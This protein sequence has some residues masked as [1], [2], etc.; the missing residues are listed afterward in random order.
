[1]AGAVGTHRRLAAIAALPRGERRVGRR[2]CLVIVLSLLTAGTSRADSASSEGASPPPRSGWLTLNQLDAYLEFEGEYTRDR[3]S[4][5]ASRRL[6]RDRQQRQHSYDFEERIGLT[7]HFTVLDPKILTVSTDLSF[8]LTQDRFVERFDG[9]EQ[10]D[11]DNGYLIHHDSRLDFFQGGKVS[12]SLYGRRDDRRINRRFQPTLNED[13]IGYGTS[14]VFSDD[15][16]PMELTYDYQETDRTGNR[17]KSD[18]EHYTES[19][20]HYGLEWIHTERHRLKLSYEH[21]DTKQ[22]FQG[23]REAFDTQR[24]LLTA[25]DEWQFG[26]GGKHS[27]R[28]LMHWQ[29]E[30]GDFARDLFE[31]GPQLTLQHT[32]SLQTLYKYQFNRERYEGLDIDTHRADFQVVHQAYTNLT[33]TFDV[34]ALQENIDGDIDTSQFGGFADWQYN[35]SNPFGHLHA[36][37]HLGYDTEDIEGDDG[38]RVVLNESGTFR[39]PRAITLR[40]R[41]VIEASIIVTDATNR[42]FFRRGVD[43]NVLRVDNAVQV[44]RIPTGSIADGDTVLI[45]YNYQIP[46]DGRLDTIRTDFS[47]EQRFTGGLTPY[48]R[49]SYRNQEDETSTGFDRRAD[50]TNHHRIGATYDRS[51]FAL[52]AEYE[53]FD[54]T[55]DPYDAFHLDGRLRVFQQEN[56]SVDLSSRL[57]RLFFEGGVDE[58]DV[59]LLDVEADHR[60]RLARDWSTVQRVAYRYEQDSVA[61]DT[62]GWDVSAGLEYASGDLSGEL[63]IEY[64][65]LDLPDSDQEDIGV[66]LRIRR[67][68]RNVVSRW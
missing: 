66:Y 1:M 7:L 34:F 47:I 25:E 13:R 22:E 38:V 6:A 26:A 60:W 29:E 57:S 35:R 58:R 53:I 17:D 15:K 68:V 61:G 20:L 24:D 63:T 36:N 62:R 9:Y 45:D 51:R 37:L 12:G 14:W 49:L 33:S 39:D 46:A 21:S 42:R 31:I 59:T 3:V 18:D 16:L 28:T 67:D 4:S 65:R 19:T 41:D 64:D 32:D 40:N 56:H 11:D 2:A 5:D 54:D 50:R 44:A 30:S 48:Y 55:V 52:G 10:T 8:A 23:L 43:Y 27:L